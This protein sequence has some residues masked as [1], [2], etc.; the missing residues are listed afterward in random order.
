MAK[1]TRTTTFQLTTSR[2]GRP[3]DPDAPLT[4]KA[5]NS[6]PHEEVDNT[7]R[8]IFRERLSFNSRPHEE[9]DLVRP[10][11][12]KHCFVFQLT[13]SRRGRRRKIRLSSPGKSF[14]SRPH[15]EVDIFNHCCVN[16]PNISFNSRPH[17]EVDYFAS[18]PIPSVPSFNSRPHE[19]VDAVCIILPDI[20]EVFQLTTSR[21]GRPTRTA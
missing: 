16:P 1:V 14:N 20:R 4:E 3:W 8:T 15:E 13:T 19:E 21:R 5:F 11:A 17:E 18:L 12:F 9:V 2:R 6:R 10:P 7:P